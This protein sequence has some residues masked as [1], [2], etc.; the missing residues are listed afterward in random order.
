MSDNEMMG[1]F[2]GYGFLVT[3]ILV[4]II[5]FGGGGGCLGN[6][7]GR[8]NNCGGGYGEAQA[9]EKQNIITAAETNYR[10]IDE[11]RRSTDLI[12]A[13]LR[14]QYDAA[15]GEK[16]FDLK[17]NALAMQQSYETKLIAKDATIER[18]TLAQQMGGRFDALAEQIAEIRCNMLGKPPVYGVGTSCNGIITPGFT[19]GGCGCGGNG[20]VL[21]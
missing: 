17:L 16:L 6:L 7:F 21:G 20:L 11:N 18:M 8:G 5:L 9:I 19:N 15:Q 14:N 10:V 12:S 4:L 3:I 2:G 13:Q 1:G